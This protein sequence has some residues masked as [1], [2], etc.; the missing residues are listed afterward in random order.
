MATSIKKK[1]SLSAILFCAIVAP[2]KLVDQTV[3]V[4]GMHVI[5]LRDIRVQSA[6]E[7]LQ[8][9]RKLPDTS[10]GGKNREDWAPDHLSRARQNIVTDYLIQDYLASTQTPLEILAKDKETAVSK[11]MGIDKGRI[12]SFL[13]DE[14]IVTLD[15]HIV[16]ERKLRLESFLENQLAFRTN[17]LDDEVKAHYEKYRQDRFL[18]REFSDVQNI[19]RADLKKEKL[20]VEFAQWIKNQIRRTEV[21]VLPIPALLK[22]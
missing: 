6:V 12:D 7:H 20:Q 18:N 21:T 14:G 15:L 19:V 16:A 10:E 17:F 4:V 9:H 11:I 8:Q 1:L 22:P 13:S 3:G 2:A 5:T